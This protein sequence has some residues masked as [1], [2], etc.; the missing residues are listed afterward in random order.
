MLDL[1]AIREDPEPYRRALARSGAA[2]DLDRV[3][4]LDEGWRQ[5]TVQVEALRAG[6]NRGSREV[7]AIGDPEERRRLIDRLRDES[8]ELKRLEPELARVEETLRE[9]GARLPNV[10][11]EDAPDGL[12]DEDN[13]EVARWGEPPLPAEAN[14]SSPGCA[15]AKATSSPTLFAG[16]ALCT[17]SI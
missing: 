1:K 6:Q 8:E 7:G 17:T 10:P 15:L 9:L 14:V 2:G 11:D 4:A 13:V 3:L 12:T 5:L 16:T